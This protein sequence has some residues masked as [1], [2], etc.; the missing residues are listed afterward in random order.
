MSPLRCE[1]EANQNSRLGMI[2]R[3]QFTFSVDQPAPPTV[4]S[5]DVKKPDLKPSAKFKDNALKRGRP[6]THST[7]NHDDTPTNIS[8]K[9]RP[10]T[11]RGSARRPTQGQDATLVGDDAASVPPRTSSVTGTWRTLGDGNTRG[12]R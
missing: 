5:I 12:W 1:R 8:D 9:D 11:Q 10:L 6:A 4:S 7:A 3:M 2:H